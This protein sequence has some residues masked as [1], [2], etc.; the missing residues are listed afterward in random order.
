M[1]RHR[2]I[3]ARKSRNWTQEEVAQKLEITAGFY[4][5]LEQGHRNP[6]LSLA[7]ALE[8]LYGVP[9]AELFPD[10]FHASKLLKSGS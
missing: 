2:L 5:M 8:R 7:F 3:K 10:L 1:R 9:V 6:R 4:G